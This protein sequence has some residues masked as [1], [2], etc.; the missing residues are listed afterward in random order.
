MTCPSR[1]QIP[2]LKILECGLL[3]AR[4]AAWAG[5]AVRSAIEADHVHDLPSLLM[6]FQPEKLSHYWHVARPDFLARSS[7]AAAPAFVTLWSA[8]E[9]HV[10]EGALL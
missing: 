2:I 9:P 10:P 3:R 7:E 4:A 6:D 5:D 1:I 8:L